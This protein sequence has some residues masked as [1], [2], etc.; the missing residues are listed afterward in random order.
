MGALV[1]ALCADFANSPPEARESDVLGLL[2]AIVGCVQG[3][4]APV[5]P[6]ILAGTFKQT[7]ALITRV[8]ARERE[9]GREEGGGALCAWAHDEANSARRTRRCRT[10]RASRSTACSSTSCCA[11]LSSTARSVRRRRDRARGTPRCVCV[12]ASAAPT[13]R[14]AEVFQLSGE[15]FKLFLDA[16]VWGGKHTAA[17]VSLVGLMATFDLV[18]TAARTPIAQ[19][20]FQSYFLLLLRE[21]FA[22]LTDSFHKNGAR[23]RGLACACTHT[24]APAVHTAFKEQCALLQ[25]MCQLV[26]SGAVQVPLWGDASVASTNQIFVRKYL[27]DLLGAAFP[28]VAV[29]VRARVAGESVCR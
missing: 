11:T 8:R 12:R 21:V 22:V 13:D 20:F 6:M 4:A 9:R 1:E 17:E 16:L 10:S 25:L 3:L 28:N 2:S 18:Q 27:D 24:S 29:Y 19:P 15:D 23:R 26:E 14:A 7:L 5:V